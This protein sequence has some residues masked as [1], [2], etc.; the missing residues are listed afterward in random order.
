MNTTAVAIATA[1]AV[2]GAFVQGICGFGFGPIS[3]SY[4]PY[5]WPYQQATAMSS[6]CGSTTAFLIALTNFRHINLKMFV[7]C[8]VTA[9]IAAPLAVN[10]SM[11]AAHGV[12]MRALGLALMALGAYQIFLNGKFTIKPT[13]VNGMIAGFVSGTMSGLF[14]MSGPPA[15][16]YMLAASRTKD[17]YRA[18]LNAQ[19]T[20][21]ALLTGIVRYVHGYINAEAMTVWA[22]SLPALAL[23]LTFGSRVF[24]R[25]DPARVRLLVNAYLIISGITMLVR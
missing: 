3:M 22:L 23:G 7:S 21:T 20:A 25:L 2:I 16:V 17:E 10:I 4:L 24:R 19:F 11:G 1:G 18:T 13:V 8:S 15:A 12:L 9:M 6:L 5:L 14:A